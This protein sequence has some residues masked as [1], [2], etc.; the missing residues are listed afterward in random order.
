MYSKEQQLFLIQSIKYG[1]N[2]RFLKV[3]EENFEL[4]KKI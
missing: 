3:E 2:E 4:S 1:T